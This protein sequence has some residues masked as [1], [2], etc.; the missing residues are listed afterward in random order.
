MHLRYFFVSL[1]IFA[2]N[3]FGLPVITDVNPPVG[4]SSGST[5][6]TIAGSGFTGATALSFGGIPA[7]FVVNSDSSI[8][9]TTPPH[10]PQVTTLSVTTPSGT[11]SS[12]INS[13]FT[14]QGTWKA[15]VTNYGGDFGGGTTVSVFDTANTAA[16]STPITVGSGPDALY[17]TPDG[18]QV[19]VANYGENAG[20]TVSII[21]TVTDTVLGTVNVGLGP[22]AVSI[23]PD[24]KQVY[25]AN[26]ATNPGTVTVIDRTNHNTP[27]TISTGIGARPDAIGITP[28]GTKAYVAN[29]GDN[30][31]S[32]INT[33]TNTVIASAIP[34]G[35]GP[36]GFSFTPDGSQVYVTNYN[37]NAIT[38]INTAANTPTTVP[39]ILGPFAA[40]V[41]PNGKQ[42]FVPNYGYH[43]TIEYAV[44]VISPSSLT[45]SDTINLGPGPCTA[46]GDNPCGPALAVITPD[47][48]KAYV[49]NYNGGYPT[50]GTVSVINTA[51][52]ALIPAT[53]NL[54]ECGPN[55]IA[56][57]PDGA[58]VF[59]ANFGGDPPNQQNTVSVIDAASNTFVRNITVNP[60]PSMIM[61]MPDQA[62]LAKF[63]VTSVGKAGHPTTFNA[64]GSVTP[65][66][67][68]V[69]YT[70]DFGDGQRVSTTN[71][72]I[73][74]RYESAGIFTPRLTVTNSGG[75]STTQIYSNTSYN[76]DSFGSLS[77]PLTNNGGPTA[78]MTQTVS[79][80]PEHPVNFHG[81]Q[82]PDCFLSQTDI[83]NL[84]TWNAPP[85]GG[86]VSY[87]IYRNPQLTQFVG[88]VLATQP[89]RFEDHNRK[90]NVSYTYYIV[91]VAENAVS[92]AVSTTVKPHV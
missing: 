43:S 31:V 7:P 45:V 3:L 57:T 62:P 71:P 74:H 46:L 20:S 84:L 90:K 48:T 76:N 55:A 24:G 34:A 61:I 41:T 32:V 75:T 10:T 85:T 19:Y 86:I 52:D 81:C 67:T 88:E 17:I 69:L 36:F 51:N 82:G 38:V 14:F 11:S 15:Y 66:G 79:I 9:A 5:T 59:I 26:Y 44:K 23:T 78:T 39:E 77:S 53:I 60:S 68:I 87:K 40:A 21:D 47:G 50:P 73:T 56:I 27:S 58:Q 89:L 92:T 70:W 18:S 12:T 30:T 91:S 2:V 49:V 37:D 65:T 13:Y 33:A 80:D 8:T 29:S 6:V 83:V 35:A 16:G 64:S 72:I 54:V 1:V 22:N 25:V 63:Q 42:V 4:P 28:D